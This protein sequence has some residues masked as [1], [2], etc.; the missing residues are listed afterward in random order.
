MRHVHP[1]IYQGEAC[2][3][4]TAAMLRAGAR[5]ERVVCTD[6]A[7]RTAIYMANRRAGHPC[8]IVLQ[9]D[10]VY[11][12]PNPK[13]EVLDPKAKAYPAWACGHSRQLGD[14]RIGPE[15][16]GSVVDLG[17]RR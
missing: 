10:R 9:G 6:V 11:M 13:P 8:R 1:A 16:M 14:W 2:E 3:M 5:G 7:S 15:T 12:Y 4:T 17:R